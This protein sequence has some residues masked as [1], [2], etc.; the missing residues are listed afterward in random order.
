MT[1]TSIAIAVGAF[2][3]PIVLTLVAGAVDMSLLGAGVAASIAGGPRFRAAGVA[4]VIGLFWLRTASF[5][6]IRLPAFGAGPFA[7]LGRNG[8]QIASVGSQWIGISFGS[9][10]AYWIAGVLTT[11][12]SEASTSAADSS[13]ADD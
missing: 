3:P 11:Q 6:E 2:A 4:A 10:T 12:K 7:A 13:R 9:V 1:A 8:L 5:G